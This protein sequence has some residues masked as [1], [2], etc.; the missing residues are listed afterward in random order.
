MFAA[1]TV[2]RSCCCDYHWVPVG[3]SGPLGNQKEPSARG[4]EN[5]LQLS[6]WSQV[7]GGKILPVLGPVN[8][9]VKLGWWW[10]S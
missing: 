8:P 9:L 10:S 3:A 2:N 5:W 1:G 4:I 6:R 7:P